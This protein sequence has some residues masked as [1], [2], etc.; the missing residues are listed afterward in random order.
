MCEE[1]VLDKD[2][3]EMITIVL[4]NTLR[5]LVFYTIGIIIN[6]TL[7]EQTRPKI[8]DKGII[9][10]LIVVLQDSNIEDLDLSKVTA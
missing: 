5:D 4:D 8:L 9:S 2:F 6:I 3:L 7:H 10:K 1:F